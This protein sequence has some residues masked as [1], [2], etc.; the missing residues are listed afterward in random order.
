MVR[1]SHH[2]GDPTSLFMSTRE[3]SA[4]TG[5]SES[6]LRYWRH[7]GGTEG[8]PSFVLGGKRVMYRRTAV[9]AW[10]AAQEEASKVGRLE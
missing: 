2:H 1:T 8:P 9:M 4:L 7:C 3:V 10:I 6:T 5:L